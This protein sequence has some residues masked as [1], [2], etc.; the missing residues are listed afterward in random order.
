MISVICT[1]SFFFDFLKISKILKITKKSRFGDPDIVKTYSKLKNKSQQTNS[2]VIW[3]DFDAKT[4]IFWFF[5]RFFVE[6]VKNF[7]SGLIIWPWIYLNRLI[8]NMGQG[9][10]TWKGLTDEK[11]SCAPLPGPELFFGMIRHGWWIMYM[12]DGSSIWMIDHP[13]GW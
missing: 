2:R 12:D 9:G 6:M 5:C 3:M 11:L 4:M 1:F 8:L 10:F 13:Y 7:R